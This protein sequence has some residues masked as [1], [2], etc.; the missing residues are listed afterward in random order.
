MQQVTLQGDA[1]GSTAHVNQPNIVVCN[2]IM[3]IVDAV[4]LPVPISE[5]AAGLT[6][7][8][9]APTA[10]A[11]AARNATATTHQPTVHKAATTKPATTKPVAHKPVA[12]AHKPA[13]SARS[14]LLRL[15]AVLFGV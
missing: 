5:V 14:Y 6:P 12:V 4:L 3:H 13:N 9:P 1:A 15:A 10:A 7:A 11:A 2:S 8:T